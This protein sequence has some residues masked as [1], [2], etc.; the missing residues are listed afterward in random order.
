MEYCSAGN[1]A[2]SAM[3]ALGISTGTNIDEHCCNA[4]KEQLINTK[5]TNLSTIYLQLIVNRNGQK[6]RF[7]NK[8][9]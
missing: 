3:L 2:S 9:R 8:K 4:V 5:A 7:K 1:N 6:P